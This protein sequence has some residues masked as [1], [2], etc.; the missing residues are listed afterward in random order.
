MLATNQTQR[1]G[2]DP[3]PFSHD[4]WDFFIKQEHIYCVPFYLN[5]SVK[6][7]FEDKSYKF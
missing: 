3:Y 4:Q 1:E 2:E 6:T 7:A 5:L